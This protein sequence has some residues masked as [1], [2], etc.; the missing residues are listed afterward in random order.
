ML[1]LNR[2]PAYKKFRNLR[3]QYRIKNKNF[4][5]LIAADTMRLYSQK[6]DDYVKLLKKMIMLNHWE[7]FD[8]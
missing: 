8:N 2:N 6:K 1:N 4:T 5:G 3:Y 7:K